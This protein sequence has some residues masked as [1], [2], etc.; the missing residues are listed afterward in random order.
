MDTPITPLTPDDVW[1]RLDPLQPDLDADPGRDGLADLPYAQLKGPGF[2]RL[3][4][5]LLVAEGATPRFFGR[6]GQADL[7]VDIIVDRPAPS[8]LYQCKNL[9]EP[10]GWREIRD[11]VEK[12]EQQWLGAADLPRPQA[13][14]YCCPQPLD[15][16]TL[17]EKLSRL[18]DAFK[19]RTGVSLDLRDKHYL[20]TRLRR[21]PDLVAG[22]FSPS[23]AEQFCGQDAWIGGPWTR[24][25]TAATGNPATRRFLERLKQGRILIREQERT[26]FDAIIE[27]E[28]VVLIRGFPGVGKSTTGLALACT[29]REP[30]RR[31][32]FASLSVDGDLARLVDGVRRR[33][34]LP[35]LFFLDDCHRDPVLTGHLLDRLDPLLNDPAGRI[36]L[37]LCQ[38][39]VPDGPDID[40]T[41]PWLDAL[42]EADCVL[43]LRGDLGR[44]R[45]IVEHRRRQDLVG[46]SD[47]RLARLH[48]QT[49]GDL[50]L[51][52][53]TLEAL[54]GP[55]D[56]D[57]L[58]P[59]P[60][61]R[62]IR[63][64]YFEPA[65]GQ[66]RAPRELPT[67]LRLA[68]LAQFELVPLAEHLRDGWLP[69]EQDVAAPLMLE[70]YS[71]RR[72]LFLHASMAELIARALV[73]LDA[74]PSGADDLYQQTT[75]SELL[76][77]LSHLAR[78]GRPGSAWIEALATVI[79]NPLRLA[80]K[81]LANALKAAV[82]ADPRVQAELNRNLRNAS[83]WLLFVCLRTMRFADHPAQSSLAKL[84]VERFRLL[85]E[86]RGEDP[87]GVATLGTGFFALAKN[88]PD[89]LVV[90]ERAYAP[91]AFIDLIAAHGTLVE[92]FMI[93][94]HA[95]SSFRTNLLDVLDESTAAELVEKTIA[96]RRS[97]GTLSLTLR[98]LGN[99]DEQALESL[100]SLIGGERFLR[101]IVANGTLFDLFRFLQ[102]ASLTLRTAL[103]DALDEPVAAALVDKT[104][105]SERSIGTLDLALRELGKT[106]PSLLVALESRIGAERLLKLI[107]ANGTLF[108]LFMI[109][110]H[111]SNRYRTAL[112]D[113]LDEQVAAALVDKTIA[114]R[115]SIGTL[116]LALRKLGDTNASL[117]KDISPLETLE[118]CV[119]AA[120]VLHLIVANGTLFELLGVLQYASPS[121]GN[122]VLDAV[123][124][125]T[126]TALVDKT[127]AAGRSIA[128]MNLALRELGRKHQ[129]LLTR[130]ES[131]IGATRFLRLI[132]ANG[133]LVDLFKVLEHVS[134]S[135][136]TDLLELVDE[137][138][139]AAL[140][141]R[142]IATSR[143]IGTV[144]LTLRELGQLDAS[145]PTGETPLEAL[146]SRIGAGAFLR[147]I[148]A[149]GTLFELFRVLQN[150]SPSFR[151]ALL[152]AL[153]ES[154]AARLV[155]KTIAAQQSIETLGFTLRALARK[156]EQ[157]RLLETVISPG[158]WWRLLVGAGT[159][160]SL[161]DFLEN[162]SPEGRR[163]L[164][165]NAVSV[166]REGWRALICRSYFNNAVDFLAGPLRNFDDDTETVFSATMESVTEQLA[167]AATWRELSTA[168]LDLLGDSP[169]ATSLRK[170]WQSRIAGI[171]PDALL[172]LDFIEAINGF[173]LAWEQRPDLRGE[174]CKHFEQI[175]PSSS[176][177]PRKS[178]E[179][180]RFR[181]ILTAACS[182]QFPAEQA[183][184]LIRRIAAFLN[185]TVC[186]QTHTLPLFLLAWNLAAV[187]IQHTDGQGFRD[188]LP[189]GLVETLFGQL[190]ARVRPKNAN[191]EK[192][193]QFA[194]A[195][196]LR[197]VEPERR[198]AIANLVLPLK[199]AVPWLA[200]EALGEEQV[201]FVT[202]RC[203]FEGI[204]LLRPLPA[205]RDLDLRGGLMAKYEQMA[206]RPQA[207]ELLAEPLLRT[208]R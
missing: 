206:E 116:G 22:L 140:V 91:E 143:S 128:T 204:A 62:S 81:G 24:V 34:S 73:D 83:F 70:L 106:D 170:A 2:E 68:C 6:S 175:I 154:T 89:A 92:L 17:G 47:E 112:L 66:P 194:L 165:S 148:V 195:G 111:S 113:K 144:N 124:D 88:A 203:A 183:L 63:R 104:I 182:C 13:F 181:F 50:L 78:H 7:G 21:A 179:I 11:A 160:H 133:T 158:G 33:R 138:T 149:N 163:D 57:E 103:L 199:G 107:V 171:G 202:A 190:Q 186:K 94:K 1:S 32:Y 196:L 82:L 23:Y 105:G 36:R 152:L 157:R 114:A 142:T 27:R 193:A 58:R 198:D 162:M 174:L 147:L 200:Q 37:V 201:G 31:I 85:F 42:T 208:R 74:A 122:A 98:E 126:V 177:W 101:L 187:R 156:P 52:D 48:H 28:P 9:T 19:A 18:R 15:D 30:I 41:R 185:A 77:Y 35:S 205:L 141:D 39:D 139:A 188:A 49:G 168:R 127:I 197:L 69:G 121:F 45:A 96:A 129:S 40:E 117:Q 161:M 65:P 136:R 118:A 72:H 60:L 145:S 172:G 110:Q 95:S 131:R 130:L 71:P 93:L 159:L 132:V 84:I 109:L 108:E 119:G 4:Y 8:T 43:T 54:D 46:L 207:V 80:A 64:R 191:K 166:G 10:P 76:D 56:L 150:V 153:D 61:Y 26:A 87:A 38:R 51:L 97:I 86:L 14:V 100:E 55:A 102:Y 178:G 167:A 67:V 59:E 169:A 146:E 184:G 90:V 20:D 120:R 135:F 53:E 25:T 189:M 180:A 134:P 173:V 155:D 99:T 3:C 123:D 137:P 176:N 29:L 16:K 5:E 125:P 79:R 164:I 75:L 151:T 115:R 192:L 44:F 12:F